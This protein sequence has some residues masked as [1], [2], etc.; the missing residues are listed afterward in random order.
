MKYILLFI[1]I[2]NGE[3]KHLHQ[4]R[5]YQNIF[6]NQV[7]GIMEY[8]LKDN[9]RVDCLTNDYAIEVDFDTK[10]SESIGQSLYY[11]LSTNKKA[12]VLLITEDTQKGI[13][14]LTRLY[15]V[16]KEHNITIWVIN[17]NADIFKFRP[18]K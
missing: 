12:G 13:K 10:W 11:G 9:T 6:C 7:N 2:L 16:A 1:F 5:Y 14:Y 17:A 8:K 15:R 3:A 18:K 4:E